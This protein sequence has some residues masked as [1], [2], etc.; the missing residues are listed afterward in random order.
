MSQAGVENSETALGGGVKRQWA[1]AWQW[2][3]LRPGWNLARSLDS[4]IRLPSLQ[5]VCSLS[6]LCLH[7]DPLEASAKSGPKNHL[8]MGKDTRERG[9]KRVVGWLQ[10]PCCSSFS[11]DDRMGMLF[12]Q[13]KGEE[14]PMQNSQCLL[15]LHPGSP[16]AFRCHR[17]HSWFSSSSVSLFQCS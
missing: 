4:R 17:Y 12:E 8:L 1:L 11:E 14:S 16:C 7:W 5:W 6:D 2:L 9:R 13:E 3:R 10:L 15:R